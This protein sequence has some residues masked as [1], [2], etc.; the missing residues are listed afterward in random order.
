MIRLHKSRQ[1][2]AL[3]A[4]AAGGHR[5]VISELLR[6][7]RVAESVD[8]G[9]MLRTACRLGNATAVSSLLALG[10]CDPLWSQRDGDS[11]IHL[12]ARSG[13]NDL[14]ELLIAAASD[15]RHRR[16]A[17]Y[18]RW[19]R[20]VKALSM[21]IEGAASGG[22]VALLESLLTREKVDLVA[23]AG[24]AAKAAA[25]GG[26]ALA[27][28]CILADPHV[29]QAVCFGLAIAGAASAGRM[30]LLASLLANPRFRMLKPEVLASARAG[31]VCSGL[32][33]GRRD[34]VELLLADEAG[35]ALAADDKA[36]SSCIVAAAG[37]DEPDILRRL[38]NV[39]AAGMAVPTLALVAGEALAAAAK[40]GKLL[41][42]E[43]LLAS[44]PTLP[45]AEPVA[46]KAAV[47]AAAAGGH[48]ATL[49]R[50]LAACS[51]A[52]RHSFTHA[53]TAEAARSDRLP[54]VEWLLD[55]ARGAM[56]GR[57]AELALHALACAVE[58]YHTQL[59][60]HLLAL[61]VLQTTELRLAALQHATTPAARSDEAALVVDWALA[62][63]SVDPAADGNAL[64]LA[65]FKSRLPAVVD[66]LL[67]DTRVDLSVHGNAMLL[68]A[69]DD[70]SVK[71]V[72][73]ALRDPRVDPGV[74]NNAAFRFAAGHGCVR[75]VKQLLAD[76]RVD[77][78][79]QD[80][81][82]IQE[83]KSAKVMRCLLA[84]PRVDP[85]ADSN[86]AVRSCAQENLLPALK[87]L[88][89]D[90]RVSV[91]ACG[92]APFVSAVTIG[93]NGVLRCLLA[94]PRSDPTKNLGE[95][96]D[97]AME[98]ECHSTIRIVLA[99]PRVQAHVVTYSGDFAGKL[100]RYACEHGQLATVQQLLA[101]LD[102]DADEVVEQ[103]LESLKTA[104]SS[105]HVAVFQALLRA[106]A[107]MPAEAVVEALF[108]AALEA[109]E[110]EFKGQRTILRMLLADGR[111]PLDNASALY[112]HACTRGS[113][114]QAAA[115][116]ANPLCEPAMPAAV[117]GTGFSQLCHAGWVHVPAVQQLL[118]HPRIL[119]GL[120][121]NAAIL[122]A[123]VRGPLPVLQVLLADP[124]LDPT[125]DS[126]AALRS[127]LSQW[128]LPHVNALLDDG[129]VWM[130]LQHTIAALQRRD[131]HAG[132]HAGD[133]GAAAAAGGRE[134]ADQLRA[135]EQ[136]Q[137]DVS[138]G[139]TA[140]AASLARKQQI[141]RGSTFVADSRLLNVLLRVAA[142]SSAATAA[143]GAAAAAAGAGAGAGAGA[144]APHAVPIAHLASAAWAR[145]RA[146]VL[147]REAALEE[148]SR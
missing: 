10:R 63:P 147:A 67:A 21:A 133:A 94:H 131:G 33:Q 125:A 116:L 35:G 118:K 102:L 87:L 141:T 13:R 145:R 36:V 15:T 23:C 78:A 82:A 148:A 112:L 83:C 20:E 49:Q 18:G 106:T 29:D 34:A 43:A 99:D 76:P 69:I 70:D 89:R 45:E 137:W 6:D 92:N 104:T 101:L 88:L 86:S 31:G 146:V 74:R 128:R 108:A 61:P 4:A 48:L 58:S 100:L 111:L 11:A 7:R 90:P 91:R 95:A 136:L 107:G 81:E 30:E 110:N 9:A 14:V 40:T 119:P 75:L 2:A 130:G 121:T 46:F 98:N 73:C 8:V 3:M 57:E 113:A 60:Q 139:W 53:A 93:H 54:A 25:A 135:A 143:A 62:D 65:A 27:V 132:G 51:D 17:P 64:L 42:V 114:R 126:S 127:A 5:K 120:H 52:Q 96:L 38:L 134:A 32:R 79:A 138:E 97:R 24:N 41:S 77:P 37:A 80:N 16:T 56:L 117:V 129:R 115:L 109:V 124:R 144:D 140:G 142:P 22:Q 50:L 59:T 39:C 47:E 1:N 28:E 19:E 71:L 12:A 55:L 122:R 68:Q 105:G 123:A 103:V 72:E 26:H 44:A 66:R 84:D 85:A